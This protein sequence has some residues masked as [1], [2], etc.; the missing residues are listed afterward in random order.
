MF[1]SRWALGG[2]GT[3]QAELAHYVLPVEKTVLAQC[4]T[5]ITTEFPHWYFH[6]FHCI[7]PEIQESPAGSFRKTPA[8]KSSGPAQ[9]FPQAEQGST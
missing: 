2:A 6:C 8:D 3:C 1:G 4:H 9:A 5:S 7:L